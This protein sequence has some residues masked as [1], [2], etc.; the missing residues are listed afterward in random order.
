MNSEERHAKWLEENK[1]QNEE[2]RLDP[3]WIAKEERHRVN[4]VREAERIH[5]W[6]KEHPEL[7]P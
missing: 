6:A 4:M 5:E 2:T 1:R 7:I 3:K